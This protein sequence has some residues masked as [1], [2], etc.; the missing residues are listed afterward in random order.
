M[1]NYEEA[2]GIRRSDLWYISKSPRH[3]KWHMDHK[4]DE[5]PSKALE[6]GIL[7]HEAILDPE[8]FIKKYIGVPKINRRSIDGR[9]S[10]EKLMKWCDEIHKVPIYEGDLKTI[11]AMMYAVELNKP[12]Y[13]LLRG[14]HEKEFYWNDDLTGEPCKCKVDCLTE[15]EGKK[16]IVDYKTTESCADG[17]FERSAMK[18]G[19]QFQAGM[20]T[21]G[22]FQ[23]TFE[24]YGF[25][26]VAQEKKP[27]YAVRVYI[28]EPGWVKRGYDQFREFIGI[29]HDCKQT[30]NWYGYEGRDNIP[31][32]LMEV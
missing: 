17:H 14:E 13:A 1:S 27:P 10:Y 3:F 18:Y 24:E 6:F 15:Y 20:Y 5:E 25:A 4:G 28:C 8:A 2:E 7:A 22:V 9:E 32:S 19:Y 31:V 23:N 26:F 29:Y 11:A 16:Y 30:G 21:E 12:A